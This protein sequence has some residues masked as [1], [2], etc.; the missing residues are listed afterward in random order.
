MLLIFLALAGLLALEKFDEIG[1]TLDASLRPNGA[2]GGGNHHRR[3]SRRGDSEHNRTRRL[4]AAA[5]KS[6][7]EN[8]HASRQ[9]NPDGSGGDIHRESHRTRSVRHAAELGDKT[10]D[11]T[12]DK[13]DGASAAE[14][15]PKPGAEAA[16]APVTASAPGSKGENT[17]AS[18]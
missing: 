16:P 1:G 2:L 13:T 5:G 12:G 15:K 8:H 14:P 4:T 7:G 9:D 11:E 6:K 17:G 10:G 18:T 3:Q